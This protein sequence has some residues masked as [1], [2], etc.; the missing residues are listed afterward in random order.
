M[1]RSEASLCY[2]RARY[3]DPASGRL[4]KEDEIGNDEGADLYAYTRNNPI[5]FRDPTGLYRLVG[6]PPVLAN[7][8]RKAIDSAIQRLGTGCKG[9]AGS[10][11][12]KVVKAL[13]EATFVYVP[14]LK[15][16]TLHVPECG[17]ASPLNTK[18]IRIGVNPFSPTRCCS[19]DSTL[20]HEAMHKAQ[21][22]ANEHEGGFGPQE[23]EDKCFGCS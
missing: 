4:L 8:M 17:S 22:S 21:N 16:P 11:G 23:M 2:Y 19:L 5:D 3:Y 14:D 12:P 9:C 7:L 18:T 15:H 10:W 1:R 13:D 6:F 20:A